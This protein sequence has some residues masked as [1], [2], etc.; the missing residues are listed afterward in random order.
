[1]QTE[2]ILLHSSVLSHPLRDTIK[3][4]TLTQVVHAIAAEHLGQL[5]KK[6]L[7]KVFS[8]VS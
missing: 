2:I 6:A 7:P 1:M 3:A 8:N 5:K 4:E